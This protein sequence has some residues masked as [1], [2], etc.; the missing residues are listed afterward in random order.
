MW[1]TRLEQVFEM[2]GRDV[3]GIEGQEGA[4]GCCEASDLLCREEDDA[5]CDVEIFK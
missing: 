3:S 1:E 5:T 4:S 2:D